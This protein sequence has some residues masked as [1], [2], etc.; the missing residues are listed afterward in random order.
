MIETTHKH[1]VIAARDIRD[2][3]AP[4]LIECQKTA[5]GQVGAIAVVP[6]AEGD[7]VHGFEVRCQCGAGVIVEC[8]YA[9]GGQ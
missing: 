5:E 4:V 8:V 1:R 2:V 7:V 9:E 3:G 6:L